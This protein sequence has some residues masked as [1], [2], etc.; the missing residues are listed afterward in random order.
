[1]T[2]IIGISG[3]KDSGKN[4]FANGIMAAVP[5]A[6]AIAFADPLKEF[7]AKVYDWPRESLESYVFK[8]EPDRRYVRLDE[9]ACRDFNDLIDAWHSVASVDIANRPPHLRGDLHQ[10]LGLT[11]EEYVDWVATGVVH[12]TPRYALQ[13]LGTEWGRGCCRET[14]INYGIRRAREL[15]RAGRLVLITDTRFVNEARAISATG[16]YVVR[17]HRD[18]KS[19]GEHGSEREQSLIQADLVVDNDGT[20]EQLHRSAAAFALGLIER[21]V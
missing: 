20:L 12:L 1:M 21:G 14:W 8:E 17:V 19:P 10:A 18:G 9:E 13:R 15:E 5:S 7:A 16:G 6:T 3:Y 4:A 11:Y 2:M